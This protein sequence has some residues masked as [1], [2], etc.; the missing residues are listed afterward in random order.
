[1][2]VYRRNVANTKQENIGKFRM[3]LKKI[4]WTRPDNRE[5]SYLNTK[6]TNKTGEIKE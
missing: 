6:F 2:F 5:I 3:T 4:N 1:M